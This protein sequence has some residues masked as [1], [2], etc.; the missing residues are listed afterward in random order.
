[1]PCLFCGAGRELTRE[2]VF[3]EWLRDLFPEVPETE[4]QSLLQPIG[5]EPWR[6][7]GAGT[8]FPRP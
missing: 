1:M 6:R 8:S 2:H 3:P 7:S 5:S 4:Y